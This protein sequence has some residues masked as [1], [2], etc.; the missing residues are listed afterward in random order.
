MTKWTT[1]NARFMRNRSK[2]IGLNSSA[3]TI[4][5]RVTHQPTSNM[6]ECG[7]HMIRGCHTRFGRPRSKRS[8]PITSM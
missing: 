8:A 1:F 5:Y 4:E 6:T 3:S 7:F 2:T